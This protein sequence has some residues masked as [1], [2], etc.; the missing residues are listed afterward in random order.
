M[1]LHWVQRIL[2][3]ARMKRPASKLAASTPAWQW[4]PAEQCGWKASTSIGAPWRIWQSGMGRGAKVLGRCE[5]K[6]GI[7]A[8]DRLVSQVMSQEPYRSAPR[9][10]GWSTIAPRTAASAARTPTKTMAQPGRCPYAHSRQLAQPDR[11]LLFHRA[12]EGPHT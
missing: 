3:G 9:C 4:L 7:A 10:S 2:Y 5:F 6:T 12:A 1:A 11:D 8:F